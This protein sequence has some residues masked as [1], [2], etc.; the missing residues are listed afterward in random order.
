[1]LHHDC[2]PVEPQCLCN[3]CVYDKYSSDK[4]TKWCC[5]RCIGKCPVLE[6]E[7]YKPERKN[8]GE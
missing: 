7:K 4:D 8:N 2:R 6:C 5:T 1:M 3:S